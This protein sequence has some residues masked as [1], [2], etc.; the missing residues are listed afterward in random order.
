MQDAQNARR[1]DIQC[2]TSPTKIERIWSRTKRAKAQPYEPFLIQMEWLFG[3][4][5]SWE[6][7][8]GLEEWESEMHI[9]KEVRTSKTFFNNLPFFIKFDLACKAQLL[10]SSSFSF[11][12]ILLRAWNLEQWGLRWPKA[13]QW[14]QTMCLGPLG[15]SGKDLATWVCCLFNLWH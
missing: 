9:G 13:P 4:S 5:V 15:L 7:R 12:L 2:M 3:M 8:W 11:L 14:W 6:E 10:R 1:Y